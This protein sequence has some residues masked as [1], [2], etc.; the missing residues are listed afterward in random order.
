MILRSVM[1]HVRDRNG[2]AVGTDLLIVVVE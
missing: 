2:F 1:N